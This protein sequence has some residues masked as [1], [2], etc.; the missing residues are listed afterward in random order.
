M[1]IASEIRSRKS[2]LFHQSTSFG[3]SSANL[4]F[5]QENTCAVADAFNVNRTY[6]PSLF[7]R[8]HTF[9]LLVTYDLPLGKGKRG[10]QTLWQIRRWRLVRIWRVHCS[11]W[12]AA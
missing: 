11:K 7:D 5:T 4:G 9:N 2:D 12:L 1:V 6:A 10:A 3:H 8:R